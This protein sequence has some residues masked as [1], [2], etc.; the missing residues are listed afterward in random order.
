[1]G[2]LN[3]GA[4]VGYALY[5]DDAKSLDDLLNKADERMY[6]HKHN[7]PMTVISMQP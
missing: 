2:Y 4:S 7:S 5:P 6:K 3:V 1:V